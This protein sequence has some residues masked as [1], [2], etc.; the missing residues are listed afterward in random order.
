M[1]G[2]GAEFLERASGDTEYTKYSIGVSG[3]RLL[4]FA[5]LLC[6]AA[7]RLDS[8]LCLGSH[9]TFY[10]WLDSPTPGNMDHERMKS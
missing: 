7:W 2:T 8:L 1:R 5:G 10:A 3:G 6:L 4:S 9:V